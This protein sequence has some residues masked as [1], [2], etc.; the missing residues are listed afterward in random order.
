VNHFRL[1]RKRIGKLLSMPMQYIFML[2]M[3]ILVSNLQTA[4]GQPQ[5]PGTIPHPQTKFSPPV[6]Q[7]PQPPPHFP[8]SQDYFVKFLK[9]QVIERVAPATNLNG[10]GSSTVSC[11]S[12]EQVV[13]GGFLEHVPISS[14]NSDD[15]R[16]IVSHMSPLPNKNGWSV[17]AFASDSSFSAVA[18]CAKIVSSLQQ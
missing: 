12:D 9:L 15:F 14:Q 4:V 1:T 17:K 13:G 8:P 16:V 2:S 3:I 18:E 10:I 5:G 11:H 7:F 6:S